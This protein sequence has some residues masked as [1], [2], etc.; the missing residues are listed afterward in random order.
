LR[1]C[2]CGGGVEGRDI[3]G[4]GED[5][6]DVCVSTVD[7]NGLGR[8]FDDLGRVDNAKTVVVMVDGDNSIEIGEMMFSS[9]CRMVDEVLADDISR[10]SSG[11][12]FARATMGS[13]SS[14]LSS[15]FSPREPTDSLSRPTSPTAMLRVRARIILF[16]TKC[17]QVSHRVFHRT[18]KA[19]TK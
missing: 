9:G 14:S 5:D 13:K 18:T 7:A 3:E 6:R 4:E 19:R 8:S 11:F 15:G 10:S 1:R 17:L 16:C 2:G 12:G